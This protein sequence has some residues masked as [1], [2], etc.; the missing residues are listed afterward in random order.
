LERVIRPALSRGHWV[1]CDRFS[2]STR[3]YQGFAGKLDPKIIEAL[4]LLVVTP[5]KPNLTLIID[6]PA[7]VGLGRAALRQAVAQPAPITKGGAAPASRTARSLVTDRFEARGIEYHRKLRDGFL[8]I[9]AAEPARCAVIDGQH[10][11][12]EV[13]QAIWAAVEARLKPGR[14]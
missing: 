1:I 3:V 11:A 13:A 8:Q 5:T 12:N 2:D 7:E 9:A 4:D 14:G 6:L 10:T